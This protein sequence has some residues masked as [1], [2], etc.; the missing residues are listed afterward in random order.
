MKKKVSILMLM[1]TM[2][3]TSCHFDNF[4]ISFGEKTIE[5]SSNI[6]K[7]EM[8][9]PAFNKNDNDVIANVKYIQSQGNDYRIVL[10][11]PDNYME[12]FSFQ[13]KDKQL[14]VSFT[15]KNLNIEPKNVDITIYAP[16][17]DYLKNSGVASIEVDRLNTDRI[18]INNSGV[19]S[20][21]LSGLNTKQV[22]AACS[23]VGS[24]TLSGTTLEAELRCTGVGSIK[25]DGLKANA[26][27]GRVSGVGG[28]KC[29]ATE[30]IKA[31]VSGVGS[32]Q[33][34]GQPQDK[35]LKRTGVGAIT[36]L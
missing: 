11:A 20:L 29:H 12:L 21:Y 3:L 2:L 33:Y 31:E 9:Q 25:A 22:D 4:H 24:I 27:V 35:E 19:G 10:S 5:P 1:G 6:V 8:T 26:V 34:A 23:G 30:S 36:E 15:E 13:V 14:D 28:I 32:L 18:E 17:I 16:T 7:K